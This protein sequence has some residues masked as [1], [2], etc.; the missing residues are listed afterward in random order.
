MADE[1]VKQVLYVELQKVLYGTLQA[2]L[3]FW[4]HL[5]EFLTKELGF[6]V[7]PYDSCIVNKEINGHQ[8]TILWHVNGLKCSHIQQSILDD[9]YEKLNDKYSK[10]TPLVIHHGKIHDYLGMMIDYSEGGK[11][12]FMMGDYVEGILDEAPADMDGFTVTHAVAN[13]FTV[14]EDAEKLD[15]KKAKMYHHL[16]A[17]SLYLCKQARPNLQTAMAF[18]TTRVK[19]PD[20]DDWKKLMQCI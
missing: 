11:V 7:N 12:K 3:L 5:T 18:L 19:Q 20:I 6:T 4:E 13:L 15:D 17:K 9:I 14:R 16:T 2:A 1:N 8:C 10:K